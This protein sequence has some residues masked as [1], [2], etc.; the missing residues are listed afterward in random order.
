M[1]IIN[2]LIY[3]INHYI[4][5]KITNRG[6]FLELTKEDLLAL[7]Q[8]D[9]ET[10]NHN[11]L[12]DVKELNLN[13]SEDIMHRSQRYFKQVKNPYT[14]KVGDVGVKLN[15]GDG[16]CLWDSLMDIVTKEECH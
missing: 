9:I 6:D 16:K 15:F 4:K 1:Q 13:I 8:A 3:R 10:I 7:K 11:K 12:Y 5:P 14:I 2:L